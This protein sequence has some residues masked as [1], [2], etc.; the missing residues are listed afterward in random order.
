MTAARKIIAG[1]NDLRVFPHAVSRLTTK[2][3]FGLNGD[4]IYGQGDN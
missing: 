1:L 4:G 3:I 2:G